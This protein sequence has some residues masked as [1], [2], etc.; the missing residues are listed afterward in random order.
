MRADSFI[1]GKV[2]ADP[3]NVSCSCS[4]NS[5]LASTRFPVFAS[6]EGKSSLRISSGCVMSG[7]FSR[8]N[9]RGAGSNGAGASSDSVGGASA[10]ATCLA[11]SALLQRFEEQAHFEN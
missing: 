9:T 5:G 6:E 8:V 4:D 1:G 11:S 3:S 10:F 7:N 2:C